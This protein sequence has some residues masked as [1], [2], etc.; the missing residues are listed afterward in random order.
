MR[1]RLVQLREEKK[2][3]V[4]MGDLNVSPGPLDHILGEPGR[5]NEYEISMQERQDGTHIEDIEDRGECG[6][7]PNLKKRFHET[8]RFGRMAWTPFTLV[9]LHTDLHATGNNE[10]GSLYRE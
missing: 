8:V 3:F 6:Y 9:S 7:T 5:E 2:E 10:V 1:E 4:W